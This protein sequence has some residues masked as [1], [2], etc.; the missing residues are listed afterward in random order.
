MS[1]V[2]AILHAPHLPPAGTNCRVGFLASRMQVTGD[3]CFEVPVE[4]IE[5]STGGFDDDTLFLSWRH[6][7]ADYSVVIADRDAQRALAQA[8]PAGL[9]A[10][11]DRGRTRL[12]YHRI[13]WRIVEI[14][15]GVIVL[16][17]AAAW[18]QSEEVT[19]WIASQVS[20][21]TERRIG[22]AMLQ[23]LRAQDTL[24]EEGR[25]VDTMQA[26]GSR[27][28][29]GS[30]YEY[31]WLIQTDDDANAY[32][33]P[34][35]IVV[36]TSGLISRMSSAEELA[37]VLAHEAQHVERRHSL[38]Q[39]I[40][41][42][43][44]AAVLAIVLGD[45]SAI[46]GIFVHQLGNLHHSRQ[47]E[48]EADREG[49]K[50]LARA[51]IPLEGMASLLEMLLAENSRAGGEQG[52]ALL[53]SHPATR[54]RIAEIEALVDVTPCDCTPLQLDWKAVQAS[55]PSVAPSPAQ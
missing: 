9:A 7:D 39:M 30:R 11:L 16:G 10:K 20:L 42:A 14:A 32:A 36:V 51:G 38:Q 49:M 28:T 19:A 47:L 17:V 21:T 23:Q 2:D 22:E 24:V 35:G 8:A 45:V 25:V 18:W 44:W 34:G 13:K 41:S 54:D 12:S 5:V 27:L 6:Q 26:I 37:A 48:G 53:S 52:I 55:L 29:P 31:R 50:A 40:H 4:A 46:T 3:E 33:I 43:G 1:E 15:L